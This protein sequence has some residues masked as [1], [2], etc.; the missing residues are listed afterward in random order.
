MITWVCNRQ[1]GNLELKCMFLVTGEIANS[2]E[3]RDSP[4]NMFVFS[5]VLPAENGYITALTSDKKHLL[6]THAEKY[7]ASP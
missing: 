7:K 5:G 1:E 3:Q 4:N 2:C 6:E